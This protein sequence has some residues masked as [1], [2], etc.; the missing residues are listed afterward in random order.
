M[1]PADELELARTLEVQTAGGAVDALRAGR[2]VLLAP[3]H[4]D[5]VVHV[6]PVDDDAAAGTAL[7]ADVL[8]ACTPPAPLPRLVRD[9]ESRLL[10][11]AR[12]ADRGA[13]YRREL[14]QLVAELKASGPAHVELARR[15]E[16]AAGRKGSASASGA[17]YRLRELARERLDELVER[18]IAGPDERN[19]R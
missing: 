9:L 10:R 19:H 16:A 11:I 8:E 5:A 4:D 15:L 13:G 1:I 17:G 12:N 2:R 3:T 7:L 14:E 6:L 18:A